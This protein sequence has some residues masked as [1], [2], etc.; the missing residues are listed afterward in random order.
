MTAK[1]TATR[2]GGVSQTLHW[3]I[4]LLILAMASWA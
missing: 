1:N 3:V 2:W 4:A